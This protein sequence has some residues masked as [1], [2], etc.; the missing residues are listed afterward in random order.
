MRVPELIDGLR[1]GWRWWTGELASMLP[2]RFRASSG[3]RAGRVDLWIARDETRIERVI[4][5]TGQRLVD[6]RPLAQFDED[7]WHE[8]AG[9]AGDEPVRVVLLAPDIYVAKLDLPRKA[10]SRI[11]QVVALQLGEI[12]PIRPEL[13]RWAITTPRI[14][15]E[16]VEV[17]VVMAQAERI[18]AI[19]GQLSDHGL[20]A[21]EIVA[22]VNGQLILL[23]AAT[24][25]RN[26]PPPWLIALALLLSIPI[27]TLMA[28][29]L[30]AWADLR[31][32][33]DLEPRA[34]AVMLLEKRARATEEL[35]QAITPL[36][37]QIAASKILDDLAGRLPKD[38][39]LGD[40]ERDPQGR[41]NLVINAG[42]PDT[43]REALAQN[44]LFKFEEVDETVGE[45]GQMRMVYRGR[46]R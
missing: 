32:I 2:R 23:E 10:A 37:R 43:V 20:V 24:E 26:A 11:R 6:P 14:E 7:G 42:D 40:A 9:L 25:V 30:F 29:S 13:L 8:L 41:L 27:T 33:D 17:G 15:T 38:A 16:R 1:A 34:Q 3:V 28:A 31:A 39:W 12:S 35:R 5:G 45:D 18:E 22:A 36:S 44:R 46:R 19:I 21:T 4:D